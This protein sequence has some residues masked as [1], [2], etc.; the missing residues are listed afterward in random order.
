[1]NTGRLLYG[2]VEDLCHALHWLYKNPRQLISQG[3]H[4]G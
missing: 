1:M 4:F 3:R 2:S